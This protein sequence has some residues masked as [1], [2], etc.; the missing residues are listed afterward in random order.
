MASMSLIPMSALGRGFMV[1]GALLGLLGFMLLGLALALAFDARADAPPAGLL[2][3]HRDA[4]Q[5]A[6]GAIARVVGVVARLVEAAGQ[7]VARL[8]AALAGAGMIGAA[9]LWWTGRGLLVHAL[10]ARVSAAA[11]L[12]LMTLS[13]LALA[14]LAGRAELRVGAVLCVALCGA[15]LQSLWAG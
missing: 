11:C 9:V 5:L 7:W 10:W 3:D 4:M 15:A 14:G 13:A 8:L 12:L 6:L 1:A 2:S